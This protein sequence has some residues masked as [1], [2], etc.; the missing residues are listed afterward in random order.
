MIAC[1]PRTVAALL[2]TAT[3]LFWAAATTVAMANTKT[4]ETINFFENM[5]FSLG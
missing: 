3:S 1:W 2:R 4:V 5:C